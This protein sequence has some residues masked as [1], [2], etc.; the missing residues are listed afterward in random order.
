MVG[1]ATNEEEE[2]VKEA[3]EET[4]EVRVGNWVVVDDCWGGGG[5]ANTCCGATVFAS[6]PAD[7]KLS[8]FRFVMISMS[9]SCNSKVDTYRK[10]KI[11]ILKRLIVL[12]EHNT[13]LL[14]NSVFNL[15]KFFL[16]VQLCKYPFIVAQATRW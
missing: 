14:S 16:L 5:R 15:G 4:E 2:E 6:F 3:V 10:S 11:Y 12:Y 1:V 8:F 13:F 9:L 7:F